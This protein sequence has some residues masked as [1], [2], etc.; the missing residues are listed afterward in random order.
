VLEIPLEDKDFKYLDES[1]A[2]AKQHA[3]EESRAHAD[4]TFGAYLQTCMQHIVTALSLHP[5][6][7][8]RQV[9]D[10]DDRDVYDVEDDHPLGSLP[11][12]WQCLQ[13][14]RSAWR[15]LEDAR[16]LHASLQALLPL[17]KPGKNDE[18]LVSGI[19]SF[20]RKLDEATHELHS[21]WREQRYPYESNEGAVTLARYSARA[22]PVT[23]NVFEI[24]EVTGG[25]IDSIYTLYMRILSD[26][27]SAAEEVEDQLGL[28][29]LP[30][31]A[32]LEDEG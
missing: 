3:A 10:D 15:R 2:R 4:K 8:P 19:L 13:Q 32:P 28:S 1:E 30:E 23:D 29:R 20:A 26:L 6:F 14:L 31:P 22:L 25:M 27:A 5:A 11:A 18:L 16:V 7:A 21:E 9:S 12:V 24:S 17:V